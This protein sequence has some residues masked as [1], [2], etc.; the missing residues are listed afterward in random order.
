[1]YLYSTT[2]FIQEQ[3][4]TSQAKAAFQRPVCQAKV[5]V[6]G[7]KVLLSFYEQSLHSD[8]LVRYSWYA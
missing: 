6:G 2:G 1:M 3:A 5:I 7:K 4:K 8:S